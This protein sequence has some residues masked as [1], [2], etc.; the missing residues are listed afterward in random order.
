MIGLG[1]NDGDIAAIDRSIEPERFLAQKIHFHNN[2]EYYSALIM[3]KSDKFLIFV[4]D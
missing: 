2:F 1:I 3:V 4:A